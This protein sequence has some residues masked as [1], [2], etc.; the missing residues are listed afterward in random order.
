MHALMGARDGHGEELRKRG[1]VEIKHGAPKSREGSSSGRDGEVGGSPVEPHGSPETG[2][3]K[4]KLDPLCLG[5][6]DL[7]TSACFIFQMLDIFFLISSPSVGRQD[8]I[9]IKLIGAGVTLPPYESWFY[10][11]LVLLCD[12]GHIS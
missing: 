2:E 10:S 11:A 5:I 8:N 4:R 1:L 7:R 6:S 3:A 9:E 12:S